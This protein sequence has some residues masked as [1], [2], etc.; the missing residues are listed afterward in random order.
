VH[1]GDEYRPLSLYDHQMAYLVGLVAVVVAVFVIPIASSVMLQPLG[2]LA[3]TIDYLVLDL[4]LP[5]Y[6]V[7]LE[8]VSMLDVGVVFLPLVVVEDVPMA[9]VLSLEEH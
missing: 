3:K 7:P 2:H 8:I 4:S 5:F 1:Y 9:L 6:H